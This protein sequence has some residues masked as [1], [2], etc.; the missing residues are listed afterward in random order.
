LAF[1]LL[2]TACFYASYRPRF[3]FA[4]RQKDD[5]DSHSPD[6]H[7]GDRQNVVRVLLFQKNKVI[8]DALLDLRR[9]NSRFRIRA[10]WLNHSNSSIGFEI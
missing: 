8:P 10:G 5:A 4:F 6:Y 3:A 9:I 2:C 7:N 1:F